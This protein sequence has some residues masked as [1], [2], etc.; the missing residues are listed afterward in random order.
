MK[1]A[2]RA[3][4]GGVVGLRRV[5]PGDFITSQ[6]VIAILNDIDA[7][8]VDFA[9]PE[10]HQQDLRVGL[11][12]RLS[13]GGIAGHRPGTIEA[14]EPQ[15]DE[16]TRT[17]TARAVVNNDDRRLLP[18]NF[19]E[20]EVVFSAN[21]DAVLVPTT[22]IIPGLRETRLFVVKDDKAE[23]RVVRLGTRLDSHVEVLEGVELGDEVVV[24]GGDGLRSGQAIRRQKS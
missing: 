15:V 6:N 16:A 4:F 12:I 20:I 10:R 5:S 13:A 3:P 1:S 23:E 7:L 9:V 8:L 22:A 14:I 24:R 21:D 19:A 18:G 2:V 11:S 17:I